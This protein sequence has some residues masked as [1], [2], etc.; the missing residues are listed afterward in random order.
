MKKK[1]PNSMLLIAAL[2]LGTFIWFFERES[3]TSSQ[4]SARE[5]TVF[6]VYPQ[7]V[8]TI[9]TERNGVRIEC[10]RSTDTWRMTYPV[11]AQVDTEVVEKMVAGMARVQR[12]DLIDEKTLEERGLTASDYG[13]DAP[14]ARITFQNDKGTFSWLV[15]NDAPLGEMLY[16]KEAGGND[17]IAAP[18][19][20]LNLIPESASWIRDKSLFR[21][22]LTDI[23]GVDISRPAGFIKLRKSDGNGWSLE[24][25]LKSRADLPNTHDLITKALSGQVADFVTDEPADLA[26][27]GLDNPPYELSLLTKNKQTLALQIGKPNPDKPETYYAKHPDH[28]TVFCVSAEWVQLLDLSSDR[29]RSRQVLGVLPAR[30]QSLQIERAGSW[31]VELTQSEKGWEITR[32]ARWESDKETMQ[33][34]LETLAQAAVIDFVDNPT[35]EQIHAVQNPEWILQFTENERTH[36]L[37][38][39]PETEESLRLVQRDEESS[40]YTVQAEITASIPEDPVQ[41]RNRTVLQVPPVEISKITQ[42]F[43]TRSHAVIKQDGQF[44][45]SDPEQQ[46]DA[47]AIAEL[48]AQISELKATKYTAYNPVSLAPYGLDTPQLRLQININSTNA[49]GHVLLLGKETEAGQYAMVQ[50]TPIVFI[51]PKPAAQAIT[52]NITVPIEKTTSASE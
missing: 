14:R 31:A 32:P 44:A 40:L 1:H 15:G 22:K 39:G 19:K 16:L 23:T 13:F 37:R 11:E 30:I 6:A 35:E 43:N 52:Q 27:Y 5:K 38:V 7:S 41:F 8:H 50:G 2:L 26:V 12:G 9:E 29:L 17:I 21:E 49:L 18:R 45:P 3:E 51:L 4:R 33:A 20:L 42:S 24:Q 36:T 48:T 10:T 47:N 25:P 46:V 34:L 28:P